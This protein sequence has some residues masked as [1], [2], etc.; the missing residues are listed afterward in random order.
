MRRRTPLDLAAAGEDRSS[1]T[2]ADLAGAY[3]LVEP[4]R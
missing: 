2:L 3:E 1:R 4:Y